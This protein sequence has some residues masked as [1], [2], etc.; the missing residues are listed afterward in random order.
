MTTGVVEIQTTTPLLKLFVTA[1]IS[2]C[3][4]ANMHDDLY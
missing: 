2:M 1:L 3:G 4:I